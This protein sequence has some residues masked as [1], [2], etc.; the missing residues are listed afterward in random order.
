[1]FNSEPFTHTGV[2]S[3]YKANDD[4]TYYMGWTLGWD[5]GFDQFNDGSNFLGGVGT[6]LNDSTKFTY[7]CTAGDLGWRGESGYSHSLVLDFALSSKWQYVMQ[8]DL[9]TADEN[10]NDTTAEALSYGVNNYLFYT[11][12]DCWKWGTRAEWWKSNQFTPET[13]SYFEVT[14]G[15]NYKANANLVL[16][17]EVKFNWTPGEDAYED[18]TGGDF[19]DVLFGM[20]AI[21]T[22]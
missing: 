2:L 1:M 3:T 21:Y 10:A 15:L 5:T 13:Q 4:T 12:N 17:P 22:F 18:A 9:L 16:R 14:T 8:S 6:K 19:N 7:L 11:I 20:D